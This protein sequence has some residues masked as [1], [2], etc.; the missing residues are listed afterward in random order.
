MHLKL[1]LTGETEARLVEQAAKIGKTPE[2]LAVEAIQEKLAG[3]TP[4]P[5]QA[6]SVAEFRAWLAAHPA[7]S[8]TVL[9]D[10]RESIYRGRGE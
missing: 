1:T 2:T 4:P 6:Q 10:S 5:P 7:S 8:A 9:D 3:E